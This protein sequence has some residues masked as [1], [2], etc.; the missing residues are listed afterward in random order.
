MRWVMVLAAGCAACS[1]GGVDPDRRADYV[2]V[3]AGQ[4]TALDAAALKTIARAATYAGV[5][6]GFGIVVAGFADEPGAPEADQ[7]QSRIRAQLV[8][9]ALVRDGVGRDRVKLI[10]RRALGGDPAIESR[11][12]DIRLDR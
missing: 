11:R 7:I 6:T 5:E 2:V 1:F 4:T 8:A 12:V 10:P 3:Y 9:D